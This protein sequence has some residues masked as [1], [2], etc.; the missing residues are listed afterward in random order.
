MIDAIDGLFSMSDSVMRTALQTL[1]SLQAPH[2][3]RRFV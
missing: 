2:L 1:Q 3:H